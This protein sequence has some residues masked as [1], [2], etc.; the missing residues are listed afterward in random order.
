MCALYTWSQSCQRMHIVTSIDRS[1]NRNFDILESLVFFVDLFL[2]CSIYKSTR[3]CVCNIY[4]IVSLF[5]VFPFCQFFIRHLSNR[6][7]ICSCIWHPLREGS[8]Y[9][10]YPHFFFLK[11]C[12]A[13]LIFQCDSVLTYSFLSLSSLEWFATNRLCQHVSIHSIDLANHFIDQTNR[14][15]YTSVHEIYFTLPLNLSIFAWINCDRKIYIFT[16]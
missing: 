9:F 2:P 14:I 7:A 6:Y 1:L 16:E 13:L 15:Q 12:P 8:V 5:V 10:S 3:V 4:S 11:I